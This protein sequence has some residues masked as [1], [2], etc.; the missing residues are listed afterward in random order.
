MTEGGAA[1]L[2]AAS[3]IEGISQY[4]ISPHLASFRGLHPNI[5]IEL[6]ITSNP[7]ELSRRK[8]DLAIRITSKPTQFS[9]GQKVCDFKAAMR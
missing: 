5:H 6:I 7:L 1:V 3:A 2:Q 9:I 4:L 8:A